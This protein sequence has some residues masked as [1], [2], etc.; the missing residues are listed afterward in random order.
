MKIINKSEMVQWKKTAVTI[1]KFDGIHIGHQK[2][3][4]RICQTK[5]KGCTPIVFTFDFSSDLCEKN[6]MPFLL[7]EK[8][9]RDTLQKFGI[10]GYVLFPMTKENRGL[11][12]E[13]FVKKILIEKLHMKSLCVG[14]DFRFGKDRTGNVALLE[15]LAEKYGFSFES[16]E[17][18]CCQGAEVS[19]SRI[20]EA[21]LNGDMR[22]A[23]AMLGRPYSFSG[24]VHHG[25]KVGRTLGTPTINVAFPDGKL[26]PAAGVYYS[27]TQIAGTSFYGITDIGTKPTVETSASYATETFLY[28][29]DAELYGLPA[30]IE[31]LHFVRKEIRFSDLEELKDQLSADKETGRIYFREL[32]E[33][34]ISYQCKR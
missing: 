33:N 24:I 12:P 7:T 16:M 6:Q 22:S 29:C 25:K 10:E 13:A 23:T 20:R 8:E 21:V 4:N 34:E 15:Q 32:E 9:K 18:E 2:L 19:S 27:R 28:D 1:G 17:K 26:R 14:K 3:L 11:D 31:L 5:E 30:E